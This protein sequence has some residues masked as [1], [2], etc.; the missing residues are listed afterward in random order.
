MSRER[1][2][3]YRE[4]VREV[5]RAEEEKLTL[6]FY[7]E[8]RT[9]CCITGLC[10]TRE[11][12]YRSIGARDDSEA[13]SKLLTAMRDPKPCIV[14]SWSMD[15]KLDDLRKLPALKFYEK[16]GGEYFTS[17]VIV[18]RDPETGVLNA[19]VHRI[20]VI[21]AKAAV[22]RIVPRHLYTMYRA[23]LARGQDLPVAVFVAPDPAIVLAAASSPPFGVFELEVA[24]A[25]KKGLEVQETPIHGLPVPR[26][27]SVVIEG[28]LTSKLAPEGPF[29]DVTG[30]YDIVRE[31]PVLEVDAI[32]VNEE[33]DFYVILPGGSE[34]KLLM[35]FPREAQIWETVSKVVPKVHKV[36]FTEG[37]CGWLHAVISISKNV[38]GDAKNA[39]LAAFTGHPSLKHVVVVD[40]DIDVDDPRCVEWAIATRFQADKDL[41][42]VP[43]ARGSTL[44]P[45]AAPDGTTCKVGIDATAP[46]KDKEKYTKAKPYYE[47][48]EQR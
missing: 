14:K 36:R 17:T 41:V 3:N 30:T 32:Y 43:R 6:R 12:L 46:V 48:L 28:R 35:G 44:D 5:F 18:A 26:C 7:V 22:V 20:M 33:H 42:L 38:D 1:A 9:P 11:K 24:A 15:R 19:S 16:D 25:L 23:A 39:I 45:S 8:G 13:Y 10:N 29:V 27:A 4:A 37:G 21:G 31:Q 40:P 34:H 47:V 2:L